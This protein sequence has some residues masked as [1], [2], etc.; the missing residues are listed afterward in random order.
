M[1]L[2]LIGF[3]FIYFDSSE[4]TITIADVTRLKVIGQ[5]MNVDSIRTY[6]TGYLEKADFV[7]LASEAKLIF[8][9]PQAIESQFNLKNLIPATL[10][11]LLR[12][13]YVLTGMPMSF[14]DRKTHV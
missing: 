7:K 13:K 12:I 9:K 2:I 10:E 3:I 6:A 14:S 5:K 8:L 4:R 11:E 1:V